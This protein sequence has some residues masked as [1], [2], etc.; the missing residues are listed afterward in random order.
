MAAP[1]MVHVLVTADTSP[2]LAGALLHRSNGR[3]GVGILRSLVAHQASPTISRS[4]A[5]KR[6]LALLRTAQLPAPQTNAP[7]LGFEVDFFWPDHRFVLEFDSFQ[8]HRTRRARERDRRK[9]GILI[10]AGYIPMRITW[11]E[12]EDEPYAVIARIAATLGRAGQQVA[13]P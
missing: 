4:A 2:Q 1:E 7:L 5:E 13:Q 6:V 9:D 3:R 12:L 8:F 11:R 10:A